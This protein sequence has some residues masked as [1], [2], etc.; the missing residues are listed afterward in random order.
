ML[1]RAGMVN[2]AEP[3]GECEQA[4]HFDNGHPVERYSKTAS[5]VQ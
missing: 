2:D 1:N 5:I 4:I 3:C